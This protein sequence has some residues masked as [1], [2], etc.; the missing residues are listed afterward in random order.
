VDTHIA[1]SLQY[2]QED[3]DGNWTLVFEDG[4]MKVPLGEVG[5]VVR[6]AWWGWDPNFNISWGVH[7]RQL[8][9]LIDLTLS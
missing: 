9:L 6:W 3:V 4:D 8:G 7:L 1:E 2:I 5:G